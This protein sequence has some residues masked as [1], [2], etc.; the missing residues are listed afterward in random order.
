MKRVHQIYQWLNDGYSNK[1]IYEKC[2]QLYSIKV[3]QTDKL[4]S[5]ARLLL[6]KRFEKD[7]IGQL[8]ELLKKLDAIHVRTFEEGETRYTESGESY[9]VYEP[10]VARQALMD[11]AKLLGLIR[12]NIDLSVNDEREYSNITEEELTSITP[13]LH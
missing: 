9:Q 10:S 2:A 13:E 8:P 7:M 6:Q 5:R 1:K 4:I 11:K 12:N 3:S